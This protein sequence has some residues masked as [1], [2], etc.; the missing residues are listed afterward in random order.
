MAGFRAHLR[1]GIAASAAAALGVHTRELVP[2]DQIPFLFGLGVFGGLLPDMDANN[3]VV[4]RVLFTL[5]GTA[6]AFFVCFS[7][8]QTLPIV[9]LAAIGVAVFLLVG[10]VLFAVFTR[11]TRHRG[12]WHSWLGMLLWSLATANAAF[13]LVGLGALQSWLAACFLGFGYLTHL[14]LDELASID[15]GRNRVKRSFGSALKASGGA[16]PASRLAMIAAVIAL[17]LHAPSLQPLIRAVGPGARFGLGFEVF[18]PAGSIEP[19]SS[20]QTT[21]ALLPASRGVHASRRTRILR[22]CSRG[23]QIPTWSE[24]W[25][26][27]Y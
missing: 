24:V 12:L 6:T 17:A 15:L 4:A 16:S 23:A 2:P 20:L 27:L 10:F 19:D 3:S 13:H 22:S 11:L 14:A 8:L 9:T 21:I 5:L 1:A 26:R 18:P 7:L 25:A